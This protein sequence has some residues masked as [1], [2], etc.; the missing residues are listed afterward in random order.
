VVYLAGG[1]E[2]IEVHFADGSVEDVAGNELSAEISASIFKR[3]GRVVRVVVHTR[4][5]L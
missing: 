5:G 4:V 2:K 1:Q 3:E